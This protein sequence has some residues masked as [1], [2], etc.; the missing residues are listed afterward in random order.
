ME[1]YLDSMGFLSEFHY[2]NHTDTLYHRLTQPNEDIIL[3]RN[4]TLRKEPEAFAKNDYFHQIASIPLIMWDK[5][6]R[7]GYQLNNSD[8]QIADREL[9]RFLRTDEGKFCMVRE[10]KV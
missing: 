3:E 2:Q 1:R 8:S 10:E 6:I 7:D 9:M 4:A 5:A